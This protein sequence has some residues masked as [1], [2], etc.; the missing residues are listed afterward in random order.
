MTQTVD[1]SAPPQIN[2]GFRSTLRNRYFQRL[3]MAQLISQT[4]QNAINYGSI[5]LL[6]QQSHSFTAVGG[7]IIAFSLPAVI[8]GVPAGVL[9]DRLD[10]RTLLW[11]SNGLRALASF[12]FVVAL[13][14]DNSNSVPIYILTFLISIIG[15]FFAPAEGASIPLLVKKGELVSALS[16]FNITFSISQA[17]GFVIVGPLIV[18][19][20]Q[21]VTLHFGTQTM[22][23]TNID[24]LFLF[25]GVMYLIST[26]LTW[27]IPGEMLI[28]NA[29]PSKVPT[30]RRMAMVWHGVA[31]AWDFVRR[32]PK[33]L[34][35]AIQLTL[36]SLVITV[37]AM[38]APLFS[39]QY[40][41]RSSALAAIV[42]VPAGLG[43]VLGSALMPRIISRIGMRRAEQAGVLGVGGSIVVIIA[44]H[45]L[46]R[47][48]APAN[49]AWA[50]LP[51]Y[52][53]VVVLAIFYIGL[54]LDLIT[55]PAQTSMQERSP[56]WLKG[57]VLALQM[58]LSN[59]GAI[60]IILIVGPAA[61]FLGLSR[62]LLLMAIAVVA[63]GLGCLQWAKRVVEE[64]EGSIQATNEDIAFKGAHSN[65]LP[66]ALTGEEG[67]SA[68][69]PLPSQPNDTVR[70]RP[71]R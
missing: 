32:H 20:A 65:P 42:F 3:W 38:I 56:D 67:Y 52:L 41:H 19:F 31:E 53:I 8:F 48:M 45:W 34:I 13:L 2:L 4:V 15:Q 30:Q 62:A 12:G 9:V 50:N 58:M 25:I 39:V 22:I 21:T 23:I 68:H 6:T 7:V 29:N 47:Q 16:L 11:V 1:R 33:L 66:H 70:R 5:V 61:D 35:A 28:G 14:I 55:L 51:L 64:N 24:W 17:L 36:G 18:L 69:R 54:S 57:R 49:N 44:A 71:T 60:P 27:F 43:L 37:I 59:G 40:L 26:A 10:K 46:A 63:G